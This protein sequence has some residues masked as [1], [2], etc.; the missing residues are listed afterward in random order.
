MTDEEQNMMIHNNVV[1]LLGASDCAVRQ[2]RVFDTRSGR[3]FIL[4]HVKLASAAKKR[5][6]KELT[7]SCHLT[8]TNVN[9]TDLSTR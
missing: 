7:G 4:G 6:R 8:E 3:V 9:V 5:L 2:S 1:S